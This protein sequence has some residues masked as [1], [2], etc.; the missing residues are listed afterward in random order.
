MKKLFGII[1]QR[2]DYIFILQN[3]QEYVKKSDAFNALLIDHSPV[4]CSK[5]K[6]YEFN[7]GE[8]KGLWEFDNSIISR[9]DFDE[10]MKQLIKNIKPQQLSESEKIDQIKWESLKYQ[11][12]EFIIIYSK[13]ISQNARRSQCKLEEKLKQIDF[14]LNSEAIFNEYTKCK[15]NLELIYEKIAEGVKMRSKY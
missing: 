10:Q 2:L 14:Q 5:S 13:K 4:F 8:G 11:I 12:C 7:K 6:R 9:T 15:S 1:Q 3:F